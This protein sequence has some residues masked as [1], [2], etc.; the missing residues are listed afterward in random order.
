MV[1]IRRA[2]NLI[3]N[4]VMAIDSVGLTSDTAHFGYC[5]GSGSAEP[6]ARASE[7]P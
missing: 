6:S 2:I 1:T 4:E 3:V 5:G 7:A